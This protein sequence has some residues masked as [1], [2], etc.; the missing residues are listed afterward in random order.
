MVDPASYSAIIRSTDDYVY[1]VD[2]NNDMALG[3]RNMEGIFKLP[4]RCLKDWYHVEH[5]GP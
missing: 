1:I 5:P 3:A 4:G 2:M